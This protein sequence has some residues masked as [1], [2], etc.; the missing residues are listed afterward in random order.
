[1]KKWLHDRSQIVF[2][3]TL[4]VYMVIWVT[5]SYIGVYVTYV[6]GP[7][8]FISGGLMYLTRPRE[9]GTPNSGDA[10]S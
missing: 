4:F 1:M 9:I 5:V 3:L 8:L 6:A 7:I 2:F 10:K